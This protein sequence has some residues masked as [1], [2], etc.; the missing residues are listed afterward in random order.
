MRRRAI[1]GEPEP[2]SKGELKRRAHSVQELADRLIAV[3]ESTLD[4]LDL[5]EALRDAV[6][7]AR[8]IN[9]GSAL[10]RQKQYVA[11]LMR[12]IDVEPLRAAL[13]SRDAERRLEARR[14]QRA[15]RWRDRVVTEGE[16]AVLALLGELPM[17]DE[18][19]FRS[20]A[21]EAR[22]EHAAGGAPRARRELFRALYAALA[23]A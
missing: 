4:S 19:G 16:P 10:V 9:G 8:R 21:D 11:K 7:L 13:E 22:R 1:P 6:L 20:L 23:D 17:L 2:P 14:F 18:P 3:P 15:E 5:P 12:R